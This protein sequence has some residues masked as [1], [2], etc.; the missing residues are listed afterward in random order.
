MLNIAIV[1]GRDFNDYE[2]MKNVLNEYI[3]NKTFIN[4]IVSGGAAGTDTLAEKYA[5]EMEIE[6]IVYRP[7]YKKYGRSAALLRNTEIVEKSD[8]VF[9][10]W[11]GKSRGTMDSINKA[12][13]M[14]RKLFVVEY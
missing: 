13:K 6:L 1:G 7:D 11:D 4:A 14:H 5:A 10:F 8:I 3:D 2:L 12:K 9:A